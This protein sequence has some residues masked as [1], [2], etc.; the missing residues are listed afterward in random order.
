MPDLFD[1]SGDRVPL[2]DADVRLF[3]DALGPDEADFAF[4]RLLSHTPWES[5]EVVIWGKKRMQPRQIAWYGDDGAAYRYS[6]ATFAPLP[7][8]GLLQRLRR[9]MEVLSGA[10]F[11]SVLLNLYRDGNDSMG[12][13]SDNEP[14][15]GPEPVIASLTLGA[16][17][18]FLFRR[19]S[20]QNGTP[21]KVML[22]HGTMLLMAGQT[23][24]NWQHAIN[25]EAGV[26]GPRISLTFRAVRTRSGSSEDRSKG[27]GPATPGP[28][29]PKRR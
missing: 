13:H 20:E 11:N 3:P 16:S 6:G 5:R 14:E 4:R 1:L 24:A 22:A 18:A 29:N 7:W 23:Q 19:R 9:R 8:T 28:V 12:W 2:A 15:L 21:V 26:T 10:R 17:R 25:K 27:A